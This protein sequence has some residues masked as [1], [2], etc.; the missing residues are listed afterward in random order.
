MEIVEHGRAIH[1]QLLETSLGAPL[2]EGS[3]WYGSYLLSKMLGQFLSGC[4]AV[5]RGGDGCGDGGY[6]D[7]KGAWHGHYWVEVTTPDGCFVVDVTADQF[8]AAP[9]VV[10]PI[11]KAA[12]QYCPGDQAVVDAQVEEAVA[13]LRQAGLSGAL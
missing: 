6:L 12:A 1:E 5:I 4:S 9:I 11:E 2:T 10:L 13:E 3:C 7:V 8:G